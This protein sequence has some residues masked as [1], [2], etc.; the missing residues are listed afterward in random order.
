[1]AHLSGA[2]DGRPSHP[3]LSRSATTIGAPAGMS[4]GSH[5]SMGPAPHGAMRSLTM[6]RRPSNPN[7]SPPRG[8]GAP[9]PG[10]PQNLTHLP[11]MRRI[12]TDVNRNAPEIHSAPFDRSYHQHSADLNNA[13]M[14][15]H[16][17][18]QGMGAPSDT[19]GGPRVHRMLSHD[20]AMTPPPGH[21]SPQHHQPHRSPSLAARGL[22]RA[23]S[24]G[25]GGGSMRR[26]N[27]DNNYMGESAT[28]SPLGVS[29]GGHYNNGANGPH[30]PF[31]DGSLNGGPYELPGRPKLAIPMGKT[32]VKVHYRDDLLKL[33]VDAHITYDELVSKLQAKVSAHLRKIRGKAS[34]SAA[35]ATGENESSFDG[36]SDLYGGQASKYGQSTPPSSVGSI[37]PSP[38]GTAGSAT[39]PS[40]SLQL[41]Q[42]AQVRIKY[43][44]EDDELVLMTD[45]EDFEMAKGYMGGD[46]SCPETN[47]V[48]R[49]ELWCID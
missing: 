13:A 41:Q 18:W 46:M 27:P 6:A 45:Q 23:G 40:L 36:G 19:S 38:P 24:N 33:L 17:N 1:M 22:N 31:D 43:R 37:Q 48:E 35:A 10:S 25:G 12:M 5:H 39:A 14:T 15:L 49:L 4:G 16:S 7:G 47:V 42:V 44:D 11:S 32:S 2:A 30:S 29:T 20:S 21:S 34:P 8:N 3:S 26:P 28:T 9:G